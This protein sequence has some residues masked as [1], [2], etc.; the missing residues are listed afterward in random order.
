MSAEGEISVIGICPK[1]SPARAGNRLRWAARWEAGGNVHPDESP[2]IG[3][4][5]TDYKVS[6]ISITGWSSEP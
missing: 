6:N 3:R 5:L 2:C 4:S 1:L